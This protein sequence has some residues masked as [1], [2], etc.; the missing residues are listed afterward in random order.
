MLEPQAPVVGN[1][2]NEVPWVTVAVTGVV[3]QLPVGED[4]T[5]GGGSATE[6]TVGAVASYWKVWLV[7]AGDVLPALSVQLPVTVA[8]LELPPE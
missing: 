6:A 4:A 2:E 5:F 1:P 8:V 3:Y 7:T